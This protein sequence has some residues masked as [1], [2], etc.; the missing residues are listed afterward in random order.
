MPLRGKKLHVLEVG[1]FEGASTTW[2]LDNLMDHAESTMTVI[3]TF[4]GGMEHQAAE[5]A[6]KYNMS[7]L[8]SRFRANVA[9]CEHVNKLRVMKARSDNALLALRQESAHFDFVYVDAS[10]VAIDVLHDAVV[11]WRMLNVHG[12]MVF[13]DFRWKGYMEDCYNPHVAI[14][15]FLRCAAPEIETRETESQMWVTK[16]PNRI[17]A[18]PNPDPALYYWEK[19]KNSALE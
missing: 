4:E 15:G 2:I 6:Q 18:T 10:H 16:V 11:C 9:K 8:E 1:S 5:N 19:D 13:D 14:L 12:V 17:P 3:D 7:T